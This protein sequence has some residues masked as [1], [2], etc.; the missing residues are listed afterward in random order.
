MAGSDNRV[1]KENEGH[2]FTGA[3]LSRI[4]RSVSTPGEAEKII[5]AR[6]KTL[7]MTFQEYVASLISYDCWAEKPHALTGDACKG[8]KS[9]KVARKA[10]AQLW[11][12][13]ITDF[14]KPD[15]TGS[16]FNHR[17]TDFVRKKLES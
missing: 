3:E 9:Q 12:E 11:K 1:P 5:Q 16:F 10:E 13:I 2:L 4:T 8:H 7:G 6:L 15:K 17:V 14:G